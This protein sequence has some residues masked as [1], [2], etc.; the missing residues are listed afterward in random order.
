MKEI[1][2]YSYEECPYCQKTKAYLKEKSITY[3][4]KDVHKEEKN[5]DEMIQLTGQMGVPVLVVRNAD[6]ENIVIGFD[7]QK[8]D[9]AL[10]T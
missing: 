2:L 5:A 7:P 1:V 4:N 10:A 6:K 9:E 3:T 8:I